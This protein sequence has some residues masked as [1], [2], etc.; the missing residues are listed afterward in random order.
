MG[1]EHRAHRDAKTYLAARRTTAT[2]PSTSKRKL[3]PQQ[4]LLLG[5]TDLYCRASGQDVFQVAA[6]PQRGFIIHAGISIWCGLSGKV[7]HGS[8]DGVE[9]LFQLLQLVR[10]V[11]PGPRRNPRLPGATVTSR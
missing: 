6:N 7:R 11:R 4:P 9:E 3:S 8:V 1:Q 2:R 5:S 10:G